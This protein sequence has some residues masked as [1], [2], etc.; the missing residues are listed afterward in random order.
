M[1]PSGKPAEGLSLSPVIPLFPLSGV[2]LLPGGQLPLNIFEPRYLNMIDDALSSHRL[3]GMI[4]TSAEAPRDG[5]PPLYTIGGVGRITAFSETDDGRYLITLTGLSR[6]EVV[7]E[8]PVAT[9]YRQA[10]VSYEQFSHDLAPRQDDEPFPREGLLHALERYF[11]ANEIQSDWESILDAPGE[12]LVNSLSMISPVAP[13]EKQALLE[14]L[15]VADRA[16]VL[17]TL[18]EIAL[19]DDPGEQGQRLN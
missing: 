17:I 9:P 19:A 16:Q 3:I 14:A 15:S 11:S 5:D 4:Q 1:T 12:A 18:I 10:E 13:P 6:F 2:I 7:R 8:L